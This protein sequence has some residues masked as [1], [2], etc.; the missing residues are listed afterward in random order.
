[1]RTYESAVEIDAGQLLGLTSS[2]RESGVELCCCG[3]HY[4]GLGEER[5]IDRSKTERSLSRTELE[6]ESQIYSDGNGR[7]LFSPCEIPEGEKDEDG[8]WTELRKQS[9]RSKRQ[10]ARKATTRV[11][12]L[13]SAIRGLFVPAG[14][15]ESGACG[16]PV[17]AVPG[18]VRVRPGGALRAFRGLMVAW[19]T[20]SFNSLLVCVGSLTLGSEKESDRRQKKCR[21]AD[22][23]RGQRGKA[24]PFG[25]A[26][27]LPRGFT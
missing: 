10:K 17:A 9:S 7:I 15:S 27:G 25:L 6:A 12:L 22:R 1:M 14:V 8:D 21:T 13:G 19:N 16:A 18:A 3:G 11:G 20:R 26:L 4:E 24:P 23:A 5:R 2:S